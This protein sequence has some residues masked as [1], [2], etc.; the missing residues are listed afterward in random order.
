MGASVITCSDAP[1]IL[2]PCEHIFDFVALLIEGFIVGQ[3]NSPAFGGGNAGLAALFGK[4]L[5]EP[6]AVIATV[7]EKRFGGRQGIKDQPCALVIAHLA[8][9]EQQRGV[10]SSGRLSCAQCGGEQPFFQEA[11]CGPVRLDLP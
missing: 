3:R 6:I 5:P 4:S 8:L 7:G 9:A 11:R 1:P 2:E 10:L